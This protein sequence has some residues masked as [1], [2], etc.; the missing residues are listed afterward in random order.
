MPEPAVQNPV[1]IFLTI[2]TVILVAPLLMERL[3][4][5]GLVGLIVGGMVIGPHGLNLLSAE[6]T[7]RTLAMV[8]LVYL[9]FS[10][11]LEID[12]PQF[13]RV[14][15]QAVVFGAFTFAVPMG[16]GILLGSWLGYSLRAAALV[17][18]VIASH[19]LVNYPLLSRLGVLRNDAVAASV[20]ATVFTDV[21]A[22]LVLAYVVRAGKGGASALD[23]GLLVLMMVAYTTLLLFVVPRLGKMFFRRS[24]GRAVDFQFILVVLFAAAVLSEVIDMH[25]IIGAFLAGLAIN[26]ALPARSSVKDR[27]LFLG[28]AFFIPVFLVYIGMIVDLGLV[29]TRSAAALEGILLI[30]AVYLSKFIPAGIASLIFGYSRDELMTLWGI[31]Q[32]QATTTLAVLLV[33]VEAGLLSVDLFNGGILMVMVTCISSSVIVQRYGMRLRPSAAAEVPKSSFERILVAVANPQT[34]ER[35]LSLAAILARS[36]KGR[37]FA[38]HVTSRR[39]GECVY[40]PEGTGPP[41]VTESLDEEEVTFMSRVD[42]SVAIGILH[43]AMENRA[44]MIILGWH[45]E[46]SFREGTLGGIIDQVIWTVNVPVLVARISTPVNAMKRLFF[47]VPPRGAD[48]GTLGEASRTMSVIASSLNLPTVVLAEEPYL[49]ELRELL[50]GNKGV[51]SLK[52]NRLGR[53]VVRDVSA[54]V[55]PQDLVLMT[56]VTSG[57]RFGPGLGRIPELLARSTKASLIFVINPG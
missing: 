34:Q 54:R 6:Y 43:A 27:I 5:P 3:R 8:G 36:V 40:D 29:F 48:P 25:V 57:V 50:S 32:A 16:A 11:G 35:L 19:A 44:S 17:G 23:L 47:V 45:G 24:A 12:L 33:G 53:S 31:S 9:M 2:V 52:I 10:V 26:S 14:R 7:M 15:N 4:L 22:L 21:S 51:P 49:E 37:L 1:A 56:T 18:A 13:R 39:E 41:A 30:L 28:E 42:L 38:L 46:R 55:T 20:G